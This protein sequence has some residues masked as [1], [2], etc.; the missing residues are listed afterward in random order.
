MSL[1]GYF[2][3]GTDTGIGKTVISC[4]LIRAL[5]ESGH[6]VAPRKPVESG[7]ET[8]NGRLFPADG[9]ALREAAGAPFPDLDRVTP[10]RYAHALA[11][12]RAA[13]LAG[14]TLH[15]E[16]LKQA[17]LADAD[18]DALRVVEGAGGFYSPL[19]E[20]GLNA[21]LAAALGL[22]VILVAPDRLGTMSHVLLCAEAI[23]HR[24]LQLALVVLNAV[25]TPQPEGMDNRAD[26]A[27][28]L[29]CPILTFPR[30]G[31]HGAGR[32]VFG[33]WLRTEA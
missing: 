28:R 30:V 32:E 17:C 7:C 19:A 5:R 3:T 31:R 11:P 8:R 33:A 14:A 6:P 9:A 18:Q 13:R 22:P 25:D 24:G 15:V 12:D 23:E 16:S 1:H 2:V 21:D 29:Q 4:A 20:D 10:Y 27:K 26:L